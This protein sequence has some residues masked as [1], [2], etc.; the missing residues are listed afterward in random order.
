MLLQDR[1]GPGWEEIRR[2][3]LTA[4]EGTEQRAVFFSGVTT[5]EQNTFL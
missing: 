2:F 5:D 3:S 4:L 1:E